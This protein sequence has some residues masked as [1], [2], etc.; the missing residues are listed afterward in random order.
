[1]TK[2]RRQN[3][4][5]YTPRRS[6]P[7]AISPS[8]RFLI[9]MIL[10]GVLVGFGYWGWRQLMKP[11]TLPIQHIDIASKEA[12]LKSSDLQK[13]AWKNLQGG[14]FSLKINKLKQGLL[15][16]PW[17][18]DV[19]LRRHWPNTLQIMVTEQQALAR[20]GKRGVINDHGEL[21]YPSVKTIPKTLPVLTGPVD[22]EKEIVF[23][24][25]KLKDSASQS[26]LSIQSLDVSPRLSYQV[27][28]SNGIVVVI[29]REDVVQRFSRL[30]QLYSRLIGRKSARVLR[31]DLRYPNGL[32]I[33]WKKEK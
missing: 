12:H 17:V 23:N 8:L 6:A 26:G 2:G 25:Q 13:V 30:M 27:R 22:D 32:A 10:A 33:R 31:V 4:N 15:D 21:F 29:G 16:L 3:S 5:R 20:W 28:L 19:S 24:F 18:A 9:P 11:D 7:V 14:F 1:M